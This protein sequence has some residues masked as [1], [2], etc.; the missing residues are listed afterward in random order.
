MTN[1]SITAHSKNTEKA[2]QEEKK[3]KRKEKSEEFKFRTQ[4]V[5]KHNF[6]GPFTGPETFPS[7]GSS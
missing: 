7:S 3:K 6:C 1:E 4:Q 5:L 2:P